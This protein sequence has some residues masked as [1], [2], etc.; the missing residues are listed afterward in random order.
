MRK[1]QVRN[2]VM[3]V[4]GDI[5]RSALAG[6]VAR[7]HAAVIERRLEK[8]SCSPEQKA[9]AVEQIMEESRNRRAE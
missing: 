1:N 2:V 6:R 3:H 4:A 9:A 5:D 8:L 7:F